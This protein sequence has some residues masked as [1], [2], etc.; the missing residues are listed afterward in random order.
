MGPE[1]H[2]KYLFKRDEKGDSIQTHR[3]E[4]TMKTDQ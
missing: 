1:C 2:H 4:S 3:G